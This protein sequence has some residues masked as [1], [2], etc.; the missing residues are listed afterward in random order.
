MEFDSFVL[1]KTSK[2]FDDLNVKARGNTAPK[3]SIPPG[4]RR[5]FQRQKTTLRW[6]VNIINLFPNNFEI[7]KRIFEDRITL[8]KSK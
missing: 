1:D 7:I 5:S 2:Y 4:E 8:D 3:R 6:M